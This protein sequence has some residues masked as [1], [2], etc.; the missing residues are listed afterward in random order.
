MC[1][2]AACCSTHCGIAA[3]R[4]CGIAAC[5]IAALKYF[6]S[7]VDLVLQTFCSVNSMQ[8]FITSMQHMVM[9]HVHKA[10]N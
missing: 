1:G 5:G 4:I 2:I 8:H 6:T 7:D 3:L 9:A 10:L